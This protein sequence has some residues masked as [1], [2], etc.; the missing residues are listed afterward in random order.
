VYLE[1]ATTRATTLSRERQGPRAVLNAL[2]RLA[3]GYGSDCERI[4]QDLA[5]AEGQLRDYQARPGKPFTLEAYLSELTALRDQLK[6]GLS[7]TTHEPGKEKRSSISELAER[8]N[9]PTTVGR[10][11]I[12]LALVVRESQVKLS[13]TPAARSV[14]INPAWVFRHPSAAATRLP[15]PGRRPEKVLTVS[16]RP[17][18]FVTA[19]PAN[20]CESH[21]WRI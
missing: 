5:V 12:I 14:T 1:G 19:N 18:W 13:E 7:G 11:A 6:A 20:G 10:S 16:C 4:R 15:S 3:G 2:E 17:D 21:C 9:T 8:L